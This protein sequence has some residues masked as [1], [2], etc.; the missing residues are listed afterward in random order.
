MIGNESLSYQKTEIVKSKTSPQG[1]GNYY[2]VGVARISSYVVNVNCVLANGA[3]LQ[4]ILYPKTENSAHLGLY[5]LE[6]LTV[7]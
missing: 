5:F 3:H 4:G 1:R 2:D 6:G 7:S